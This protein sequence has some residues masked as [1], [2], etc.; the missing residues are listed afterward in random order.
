MELIAEDP[1]ITMVSRLISSFNKVSSCRCKKNEELP[2]FVGRFRGLAAE[3]LMH[4]NPSSSSQVGE[5]L[6][7][8]LLNNA[9]LEKATLTNAKLQ[10]IALDEQRIKEC[11]ETDVLKIRQKYFD[12]MRSALERLRPLSSG[13]VYVPREPQSTLYLRGFNDFRRSVRKEPKEL[14]YLADDL[15]VKTQRETPTPSKGFLG[16]LKR[17]VTL[18]DAVSVLG[19]LTLTSGSS[20]YVSS[21]EVESLLSRNVI[22][23]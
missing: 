8:T 9:N 21:K 3:H 22:G 19:N 11:D 12:N 5:V 18:E 7:I 4:A 14:S 16:H 1:P 6:A 15:P 23:M 10:L 20:N 17:N 2:A 13:T